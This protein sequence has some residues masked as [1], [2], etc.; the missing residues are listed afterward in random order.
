MNT[1]FRGAVRAPPTRRAASV[2]VVDDR[3]ENRN[4]AEGDP[5]G[6]PRRRSGVGSGGAEALDEDFAIILSTWSWA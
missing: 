6:V 3:S 5:R 4:R 1:T 2:L